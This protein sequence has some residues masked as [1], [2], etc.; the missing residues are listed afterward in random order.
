MFK[1]IGKS[2]VFKLRSTLIR[3]KN[4][5]QIRFSTPL[6]IP[7]SFNAVIDGELVFM[8]DATLG[9]GVYFGVPNE[10]KL[11][12]GENVYFGRNVLIAARGTLKIGNDCMI[13]P[14]VMIYDH[15]HKVV[16]GTVQATDF[17]VSPVTIGNNC[18][19]GAGAIILRGSQIGDNAIIGAGSII[20]G[21]IPNNSIVYSEHKTILKSTCK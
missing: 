3:V 13:A 19:I 21:I 16:Q 18:W 4:K 20:K 17:C 11:I 10:G 7:R 6:F 1:R 12:I 9:D 15:D 14:N 2:I 8:G 5:G